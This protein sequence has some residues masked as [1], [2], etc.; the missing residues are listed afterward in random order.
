MYPDQKMK[1]A[2]SSEIFFPE[3]SLNIHQTLWLHI[4]EH[5]TFIVNSVRTSSVPAFLLTN[6]VGSVN[7]SQFSS[8]LDDR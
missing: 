5:I 1:A 8:L 6:K 2:V 4:T 3:R 7:F